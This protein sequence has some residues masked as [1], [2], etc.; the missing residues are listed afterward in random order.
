[1]LLLVF[2]VSKYELYTNHDCNYNVYPKYNY[3]NNS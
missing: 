1:M 2:G 3:E